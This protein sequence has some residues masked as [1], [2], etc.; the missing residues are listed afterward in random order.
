IYSL[1]ISSEK[2]V[3][4]SLLPLHH[5]Y[6]FTGTLLV[7]LLEGAAI[8]Y[9]A[10]INPEDILSCI[11]DTGVTVLAAV[12]QLFSLLQSRIKNEMKHMPLILRILINIF[13]EIFAGIR[14]VSGLN[15]NKYLL[16]KLHSRFGKSLRFLISGGARLD[17]EITRD[18]MRWGFIILEG[19]GLTET[20]PIITLM[21]PKKV[22]PGSVGKPLPGVTVKIENKN[23]EGIGEIN[24]CGKNVMLGYFKMPEETKNVLQ[25]GCFFTGDL[26]YFDDEGY[27]FLTGRKDEIIT[28]N[29]GKKINPEELERQY[30]ACPFIKEICVLSVESK[31]GGG[32][33]KK[34]IALVVPDEDYFRARGM[35]NI[36]EK[37]R[38]EMENISNRMGTSRHLQG[39]VFTVQKFPRTSLGK[40]MRHK[41]DVSALKTSDFSSNQNL[42]PDREEEA[43]LALEINRK[44]LKTAS[45]KLK[46]EVHLK[47]HLELDLGLDSL[48]R[49]ELFLDIQPLLN[50]DVPDSVI[51]ELFY[52]NT[53]KELLLKLKPLLG[54]ATGEIKEKEFAWSEALKEQPGSG[55]LKRIALF[56]TF[57]YRVINVLFQL[58]FIAIFR[59]LFLMRVRNRSAMPYNGPCI[60]V[61][62]H[63][64]YFDAFIIFA[65]LPFKSAINTYF[66]GFKK[67]F[68][69]PVI[70]HM[71]KVAKLLPLDISLDV[72]EVMKT[73]SYL[74]KHDKMICY[75]PE[76]ERSID[77]N[78]MRFK[79]GIG[80]L[81]KELNI[82]IMPVYIDGAYRSWS[83]RMR[84]PKLARLTVTFG[85]LTTYS[86]LFPTSE[87]IDY[88]DVAEKLRQKLVEIEKS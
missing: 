47:D 42:P 31:E 80:I 37:I 45:E 81:A 65:A 17:P 48:G 52:C 54:N 60:I 18:F 58:G 4:I 12:P 66:I 24:A 69:F 13:I 77:G 43:L 29:T 19:Y 6:P 28:L 61:P 9:P 71:I 68:Y 16:G 2:D 84:V 8:S 25:N 10:S 50:I 83:R 35:L 78:V 3:F 88:E 79:K 72:V 15:L 5:T 26:G 49:I 64:S 30:G 53:I 55:T 36:E 11:R 23:E 74:L 41:I 67:Y 14:S 46:R 59:V 62:N 21:T 63:T 32:A 38:W 44:I 85:K 70:R 22:K 51:L 76:G 73:C 20:S 34:L 82:P 56:P 33:Q 7:P 57:G 1:N 39:I 87:A 86:Q 75:F 27:L 40:I